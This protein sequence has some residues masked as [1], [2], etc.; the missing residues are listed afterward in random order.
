M[1][2]SFNW[3]KD[4]I[5][6]SISPEEVSDHL[7]FSGLEVETLEKVESIK[8]GLEGLV[9][10]KVL[11][12]EPHSNADKLKMCKVDTGL[13]ESLSIVCGAPN[14]AQDQ[15]VIVAPVGTT[16]HPTNGESF[17]INKA[18][19]RGE[20]SE[21]MICGE[22]EIG[23]GSS[24][25][26]IFVFEEDH[27]PGTSLRDI[28][29]IEEDF[30]IEIGL[31]P[32]R[33]D[34]F[35]HIGVARDLAAVLNVKT[36]TQIKLPE[37]PELQTNGT[38]L[39]DVVVEDHQKC[40]RYAGVEIKNL[41]VKESPDWLKNRLQVIGLSPINNIVDITNYVN[42]EMGQPLHA[43]DRDKIAGNKIVVRKASVGEK[44]ITLDDKERSLDA[45]D[46][47]IC[48]AEKGMCIAGVFG[49][50]YSGVS[51]STSSI[52]LESAYFN[53]ISVRKTAKRHQLNTDSSFRFERGVDPDNTV[54]ALKRAASLI[55][56]LAGGEIEGELKDIYPEP[57]NG[58]QVDYA[59]D[60]ARK[61]IGKDIPKEKVLSILNSLDIEVLAESDQ[62]LKLF[63]PPY[64]VDVQRPIDVV[65][66]VLRIYGYN[67]IELPETMQI[68]LLHSDEKDQDK[69]VNMVADFLVARGMT[70]IMSNSL[71][72]SSYTELLNDERA[73]SIL[74]P[75]S[76]ELDILRRSLVFN[77]LEAIVY[78]QN[79][80]LEDL[81]LFEFGKTYLK[82]DDGYSET[83]QLVLFFT[84]RRQP[85]SWLNDQS[86]ADETDITD[87]LQAL[88]KKL[89]VFNKFKLEAQSN[90]ILSQVSKLKLS[91]KE[92]A[93]VGRL[94]P[95]L[96]KK[97]D[98][99]NAVY[100]ALINWDNLFGLINDKSEVFTDIPK[101]PFVRR[102]FSLLLDKS[103]PFSEIQKI[104]QQKGGHLLKDVDLFDVYEG[105]N[106]PEGKKSYA[107]KFVWLDQKQT[108]KDEI[109]DKLM[110]DIRKSLEN[111]VGA[112]L[113]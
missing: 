31:T 45:E 110:N 14:V 54:N 40:P 36:P 63:V 6:I 90:S 60:Y 12:V 105:K 26:G 68:A 111:E 103:V 38:N 89:G 47:M 25:D 23:L 5:D 44:F 74:N 53:P 83:K 66:E 48:D 97:F 87:T 86:S 93:E 76:N 69:Y 88:F 33:A 85:E 94:K 82:T 95:E 29:T 20:I 64:R 84:G 91:K 15:R 78:N 107:V 100:V 30:M 34:G 62:M 98:I 3:L 27:K 106:L 21:G 1:K 37:I 11:T 77:G 8:G 57:L 72:K 58:F 67:N 70:E 18:K 73:V 28:F 42:H 9:V 2:I 102:D 7:T 92:V 71:T 43:F 51:D 10:G 61:I 101:F 59:F 99:N 65:E 4:F 56:E 81:A 32:N 75:L 13:A 96:Q 50:S 108:L 109:V 55:L 17:K 49:G 52:F 113:R 19:I 104:A 41:Q 46:L 112:S 79:R 80:Q 16:V 35:S 22:D 24:H 39:I